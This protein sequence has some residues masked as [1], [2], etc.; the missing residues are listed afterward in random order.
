MSADDITDDDM[1]QFVYF[2]NDRLCMLVVVR[3]P[4]F[5]MAIS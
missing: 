5:K 2:M 1:M 3:W 4:S